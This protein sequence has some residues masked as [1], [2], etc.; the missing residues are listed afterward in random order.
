MT[1]GP[2]I[3]QDHQEQHDHES[4]PSRTDDARPRKSD[5]GRGESSDGP[6]Y[7]RHDHGQHARQRLQHM[8]HRPNPLACPEVDAERPQNSR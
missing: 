4:E 2:P 7:R 3:A 5:R 1:N 6:T 8:A